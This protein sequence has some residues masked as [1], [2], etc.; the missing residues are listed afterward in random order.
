MS[1]GVTETEQNNNYQGIIIKSPKNEYYILLEQIGSG[2]FS[3]VW[4]SQNIFS[5]KLYALKI[6]NCDDIKSGQKEIDAYNMLKNK[7]KNI[8]TIEDHFIYQFD[9][10]S[11]QLVIVF[12]LLACSLQDLLECTQYNNGLPCNIVKK[13]I[14]QL[15]ETLIILHENNIIHTDIKPE[16]ILIKGVNVAQQILINKVLTFNLKKQVNEQIKNPKE[17]LNK[18]DMMILNKLGLKLIENL[19]PNYSEQSLSSSTT[20]LATDIDLISLESTE[21]NL[22]EINVNNNNNNNDIN[23]D[24]N[25]DGNNSD[26]NLFIDVKYIDDIQIKIGDL[27][28]IITDKKHFDIQ[29]RYYRAPEIILQ[30]EYNHK[31]DN[32][33]IGCMIY[34]LLTGKILFNPDKTSLNNRD[35][36]HLYEFISYL[37]LIPNDI[38]NL[39]Q[40]KEYFFTTNNLLKGFTKIN[41]IGIDTQVNKLNITNFDKKILFDLLYKLLNYNPIIRLDLKD[42]LS[43]DFVN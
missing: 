26:N 17:K 31:I 5:E 29:T 27:G 16:N 28:T 10:E 25:I 40:K 23:N 22:S 21:T 4:C 32:W 24:V 34:E 6:L 18:S 2:S 39:S 19:F 35:R 33:S 30:Y 43:H 15:A 42:I 37:G 38:I 3:T 9:D 41:Y 14:K 7:T 11:E 12:E 1:S 8:C 13:I 36:H 20:N